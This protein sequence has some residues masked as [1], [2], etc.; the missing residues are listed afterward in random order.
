MNFCHS[1]LFH[2]KTRVC[3]KYFVHDNRLRTWLQCFGKTEVPFHKNLNRNPIEIRTSGKRL[4]VKNY[5]LLRADGLRKGGWGE[6]L[7]NRQSVIFYQVIFW[8]FISTV[9][10]LGGAKSG[11]TSIKCCDITCNVYKNCKM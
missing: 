11:Q 8:W 4:S 10:L 7:L 2:M 1:A 3:L 9:I 5:C 6:G